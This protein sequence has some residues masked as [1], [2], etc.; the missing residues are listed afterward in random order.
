MDSSIYGEL[1]DLEVFQL[2]KHRY[3]A[4]ATAW[5][6]KDTERY[7]SLLFPEGDFG[8]RRVADIPLMGGLTK[9]QNFLNGFDSLF[10]KMSGN[11]NDERALQDVTEQA[12]LCDEAA[13][14]SKC[15]DEFVE[16]YHEVLKS[17]WRNLSFYLEFLACQFPSV[18]SNA[19]LNPTKLDTIKERLWGEQCRTMFLDLMKDGECQE[20]WM[21]QEESGIFECAENE[22]ERGSLELWAEVIHVWYQSPVFEY[23]KI[24]DA[25]QK[26]RKESVKKFVS[27][28][29][30][31]ELS[32]A[33]DVGDAIAAAM[34]PNDSTKKKKKKAE[35]QINDLTTWTAAAKSF[36]SGF[37]PRIV[38]NTFFRNKNLE[39]SNDIPEA[40]SLAMDVITEHPSVRFLNEEKKKAVLYE[41]FCTGNDKVNEK[42]VDLLAQTYSV[43]SLGLN[44]D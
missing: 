27:L 31:K 20:G 40:Y 11:M 2:R 15:M 22:F 38:A 36:R 24:N 17:L 30:E 13:G 21:H 1:S 33:K 42:G 4:L 8:R 18:P 35:K 29:F 19:P 3:F 34:V 44:R 14:D 23:E 10:S 12:L 26:S 5:A 41:L 43:K 28:L 9:A 32:K 6:K 39:E 7:F 37:F 16:E 25:Y